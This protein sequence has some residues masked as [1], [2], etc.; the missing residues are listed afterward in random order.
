MEDTTRLP[1]VGAGSRFD[2]PITDA[3]PD[4]TFDDVRQ[5]VLMA[6]DMGIDEDA[7]LDGMLNDRKTATCQL[8][9]H[10]EVHPKTAEIDEG[11]ITRSHVHIITLHQRTVLPSVR[12]TKRVVSTP[13]LTRCLA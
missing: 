4:S 12:S 2:F 10:L 7:W 6:V 3:R 9:A 11:P 8:T 5:L 13:S 1:N